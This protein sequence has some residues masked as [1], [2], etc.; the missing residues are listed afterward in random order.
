MGPSG[1]ATS[2]PAAVDGAPVSDQHGLTMANDTV[3]P[4]LADPIA[5]A[6]GAPALR[7]LRDVGIATYAQ[8]T[9]W[10]VDELIRLHAVGPT[11]LGILE[12]QLSERD[13][14]FA[15]PSAA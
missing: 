6:I 13:A 7:A 8:L 1:T 10:S 14:S 3:R 15:P 4:S 11:A 12:E 9:E 5:P 2:V